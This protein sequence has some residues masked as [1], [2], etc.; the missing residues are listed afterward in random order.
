MLAPYACD[1]QKTRGRLYHEE[2]TSYRNE[3]ERDRDR[4]I[5]SNAFRRLEHKTQV[6]ITHEGDHFRNRLTHSI[7]V[8]SVAR[9]IAKA[10]RLSE[11]LAETVA[12]AHDLGHAPFGHTGEE[13][14]NLCTQKSEP[15]LHNVHSFKIVTQLECRYASYDG[16][17]LTAEV[18]DGIV[19]H[20]GPITNEVPK[21]IAKYDQLHELSLTT[22]P[23]AE[24]QIASLADD[25][26]YVCHDFEDAI[27]EGL[28]ELNELS[29]IELL[30]GYLKEVR[31][32]YHGAS[33]SKLIYE[34]ARKL[35][36]RLINDL[37][38]TTRDN[39]AYYNIQ[40][41]E[42]IQKMD[43]FLVSF[44]DSMKK[45]MLEIKT[46]LFQKVYK[47]DK[48]NSI[49]EKCI[50]I[51]TALFNLYFNDINALPSE[52]KKLCLDADLTDRSVHVADYIAG[53][54]DRFAIKQYETYCVVS[55]N[56]KS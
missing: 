19:K 54:T 16:L 4:I 55:F 42:D 33:D 37:L 1:P 25:I 6:F 39:I 30:D 27:R 50:K 45:I 24:A 20:N 18:L 51:V 12:L 3:F 44:S 15:F 17:N 40:T 10:L 53:M 7:E 41:L 5:H 49:N 9:S 8:S 56:S 32:R 34:I 52:W 21:Y 29:Q 38:Q 47:H 13:A 28:L 31:S 11:H 46:F 22:Y 35:T 23:S 48:Q 36:H 2:P 26:A 14:L 43:R